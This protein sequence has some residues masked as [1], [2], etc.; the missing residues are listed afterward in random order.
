[1]VIAPDGFGY[2][3]SND[4][5][6]FVRFST[7]KKGTVEQ[8]GSL[9]DD[10]SN[11]NVSV[12]NRCSSFGGDMVSDDKGNLFII[13]AR[14]HVFKVNT[15]TKMA[16]HVST[17]KNLPANFTVNGAVV[18][19]DGSLLVSSAVDGSAYYVVN[20][21][22][23][24]ASKYAGAAAVYRSS[25]LANSNYLSS[26]TTTRPEIRNVSTVKSSLEN[27]YQGQISVYPNPV[28]DNNFTIS[29]NKIPNGDYTLEMTDILGR[30]IMQQRVVVQNEGQTQNIS[31]NSNEA[32]GTYLVRLV[33]RSNQSLFSQKVLV[34]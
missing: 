17:I 22:D 15:E 16:T 26:K 6:T 18:D 21:A 1:M 24:N 5:N 28:T 34:Q 12:H 30:R 19:A 3:I 7:G 32:K 25:D 11:S 31:L 33:D 4:G 27:R 10:P 14:N 20:P 9:V 2:A 23:W 13:S 8:L 29:F